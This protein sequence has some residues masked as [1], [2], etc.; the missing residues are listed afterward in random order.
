M[1]QYFNKVLLMYAREF[2]SVQMFSG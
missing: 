2:T 1:F